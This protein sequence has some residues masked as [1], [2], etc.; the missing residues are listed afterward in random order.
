MD[1]D[2]MSARSLATMRTMRAARLWIAAFLAIA[3][4]APSPPGLH[5]DRWAHV[6]L[7]ALP[8]AIRTALSAVWPLGEAPLAVTLLVLLTLDG[9]L[10]WGSRLRA[11]TA[12]VVTEAVEVAFKHYGIG[13]ATPAT[14]VP[15][16]HWVGALTRHLMVPLPGP[17]AARLAHFRTFGAFPSGHVLRLTLVANYLV[18]WPNVVLPVLSATI[19]G[20]GVVATGGHSFTDALGGATLA[21]GALAAIGRLPAL[22]LPKGTPVPPAPPGPSREMPPDPAPEAQ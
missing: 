20:V 2:R 4:V 19:V 14:A 1:S 21:F 7:A 16:P 22:R 8:H 3:A 11:W 9:R 5:F 12:L 15:L 13:S 17:L 6:H 10:D 18:P